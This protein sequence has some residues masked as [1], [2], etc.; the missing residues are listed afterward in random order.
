MVLDGSGAG[1]GAN[2]LTFTSGGGS[3]VVGLAIV[4][5]TSNAGQGG[6]GIYLR[7]PAG[8]NVIEGDFLGLGAD[9]VTAKPNDS[10]IVVSSP[11]NTI[12]GSTAAARDVISGNN[13]SGVLIVGSGATGNLVIGDYIGLDIAGFLAEGNLYGVDL[14]APNNTVGGTAEAD[15]NV[16]SGNVG[17][18]GQ[19]GVGI[20][21]QGQATNDLVIDNKIGLDAVGQAA[22]MNVYGVYFG[23]PGGSAGDHVAQ[24]SIGGSVAGSGNLISGNFIG[25]TG[26]VTSSLIAGNFIGLGPSGNKVIPNGD[27]IFL[28]ANLTTIGGTTSNSANVISGSSPTIAAGTGI[29]LTGDSDVIQGNF[30]GTSG[31]GSSLA[32]AGN[33][34]GMALHVTNSTIGGSMAGA[35]NLISGNSGDAITLDGNG[36]VTIQGNVIGLSRATTALGNGGNGINLTIAAPG[37]TPT[38]PLLLNDSIGGV[39]SGAGNTIVNSKGAGIVVHNHYGSQPVLGL[40][41][42]GNAIFGND[43]LGIDL[44]GTGVPVPSYLF[45]GSNTVANGQET[46]AA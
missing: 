34:V 1:K 32:G 44:T 25:I 12:G 46:S 33:V 21:F 4:G 40:G 31:N 6:A 3:T 22:V 24:D 28:G 15:A 42:R 20:L 41:I 18:T 16:I 27:G 8:H 5:F 35:G 13:N 45:I 10:G 38:S 14:A 7:G 30:L 29:D 43:K 37:T 36:G 23:T 9:G 26:N 19:T 11:G 17:P 39:A 2:G